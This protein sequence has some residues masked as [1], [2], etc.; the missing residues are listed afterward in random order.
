MT[1][2]RVMEMRN[3]GR[4]TIILA[5]LALPTVYIVRI[6]PNKLEMQQEARVKFKMK[7]LT[8]I[9]KS[10]LISHRGKSMINHHLN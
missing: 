8:L 9:C 4:N 1:R 6:L 5:L 2:R 7:M 10:I 3:R